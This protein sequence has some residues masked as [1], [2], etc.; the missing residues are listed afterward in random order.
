MK[1]LNVGGGGRSLPPLFNGWDQ[2][3]L[4]IDDSVHPDIC[5][6]AKDMFHLP[7]KTYDAVYCS[8]NLEHFYRHD[9]PRVLEGFHHVLTD[10]GFVLIK[11]PDM[12]SLFASVQGRD[13]SDTWYM[14][15]ENPISFHDVLY[16]WGLQ[17]ERGNLYYSHKT[18][19]TD[20]SLRVAL[21]KAGFPQ[22]FT[23]IEGMG[24]LHAIA[25]KSY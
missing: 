14:A 7:P 25:Y 24:N 18:G 15:G 9:V 11:V 12:T 21:N 19:F 13:I 20:K 17:M 1:V 3:L 23:S 2:D 5:C 10:A 22:V 8:H 6:D 16:G 4:D